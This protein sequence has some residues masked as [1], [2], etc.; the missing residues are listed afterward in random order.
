M[1]RK[2]E[3]TLEVLQQEY[4][5]LWF[6]LVSLLVFTGRGGGDTDGAL[7]DRDVDLL[8]DRRCG[9]DVEDRVFVDIRFIV[10]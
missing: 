10:E 3:R 8:A 6:S 7:V 9:G 1:G 5:G 4:Q 2:D